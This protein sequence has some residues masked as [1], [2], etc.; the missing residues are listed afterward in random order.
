MKRVLLLLFLL[1]SITCLSQNR[2]S[3]YSITGNVQYK[4]RN[5]SEWIRA[6]KRMPLHLGDFIKI[7]QNGEVSVLDGYT[8]CIY[9]SKHSGSYK[10]RSIIR[11]AQDGRSS[12]MRR[13]G[14]ELVNNTINSKE[15]MIRFRTI[16][17]VKMGGASLEDSIAS[18]LY[19][20]L[21]NGMDNSSVNV[22]NQ[23]C[24]KK[25]C[26]SKYY[27]TFEITNN[28][29]MGYFYNVARI[30]RDMKKIFICFNISEIYEN[31]GLE[32]S[33]FIPSGGTISF[34]E[35]PFAP[36]KKEEYILFALDKE[37]SVEA[38]QLI[39]DKGYEG[40]GVISPSESID[41]CVGKNTD[42]INCNEK[43]E[44]GNGGFE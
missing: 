5:G 27:L 4:S 31:E 43:Y 34:N 7:P 20:Y 6:E 15:E 1:N 18:L 25:V 17:G 24:F 10:V 32:L 30:D 8:S 22:N 44:Y 11:N 38:L 28:S 40:E 37:F 3:I 9:I 36:S 23:L 13:L 39:L 33:L 12:M 21:Y 2:Y 42:Y 29:P 14:E 16:G 26:P 19:S 41:F 35:F